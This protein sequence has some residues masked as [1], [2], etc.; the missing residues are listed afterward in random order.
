M[1]FST[2]LNVYLSEQFSYY[3]LKA[4]EES[5]SVAHEIINVST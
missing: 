5:A 1:H 4:H 3:L 2:E